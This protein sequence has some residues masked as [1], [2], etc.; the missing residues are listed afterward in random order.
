MTRKPGWIA[1]KGDGQQA[2]G[3]REQLMAHSKKRRAT[4]EEQNVGRSFRPA[5]ADGA[6]RKVGERIQG[7]HVGNV[8]YFLNPSPPSVG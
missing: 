3:D 2:M 6:L 5:E 8:F 1:K 4:S 7:R